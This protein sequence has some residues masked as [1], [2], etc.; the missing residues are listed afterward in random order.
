MKNIIDKSIVSRKN[1]YVIGFAIIVF[2]LLTAFSVYKW[3]VFHNVALTE[4]FFEFLVAVFLYERG[5]SKYTVQMQTKRLVIKKVGL[6]GKRNFEIPYRS[7]VGIY[8]YRPKLMGAVK[9]RRTWRM[10]SALDGRQV[11][12]VAYQLPGKKGVMDN[13]RIYVKLSDPMVRALYEIM[14]NRVMISENQV[15]VDMILGEDG[16]QKSNNDQSNMN[17]DP[18]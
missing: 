10:H 1:I 2:L 6:F 9:F 15:A 16:Q 5:W 12:T 8:T 14:P 7:I 4:I 11:L 3:I 13:Y 17:R 18:K